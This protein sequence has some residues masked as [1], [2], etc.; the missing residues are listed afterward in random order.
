M[1]EQ[2]KAELSKYGVAEISYKTGLSISTVSNILSGV[3]KNPNMKTIE[4][5][6]EFLKSKE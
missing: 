3:N 4:A 2:L 6:Q 1:L 5:L